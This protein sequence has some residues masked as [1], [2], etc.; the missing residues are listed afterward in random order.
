MISYADETGHSKDPNKEV[1][2][3]GALLASS[4][5]WAIFDTEWKRVLRENGATEPF[6]MMEFSAFKGQFSLSAW[7][8]PKR[9]KLLGELM[10]VIEM[11]D[12]VPIGAV[13]FI[14]DFNSLSEAQQQQLVD[15]YFVAFQ[16]VTYNL[17]MAAGLLNFPP[18]PAK[19][20]YARQR[21][22]SGRAR[23]LWRVFKAANPLVGLSMGSYEEGE[24]LHHAPL[25]AADLWAYELGRHFQYVLPQ[26]KP[27]RWAMKRL[28]YLGMRTGP[29]NQLFTSFNRD[30]LLGKVDAD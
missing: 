29:G 19:M 15:P 14:K 30:D 6:H 8:E 22:Y 1:V 10:S 17:G 9:R 2:G 23:E 27:W 11:A 7:D 26:G 13:V 21:E 24:P 18:I 28:V 20:I 4:E 12:A 25:Q 5:K 3:I 16:F